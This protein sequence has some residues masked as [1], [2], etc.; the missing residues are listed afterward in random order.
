MVKAKISPKQKKYSKN[1]S[2]Q[3]IKAKAKLI[4]YSPTE[5]IIKGDVI[6]RAIFECLR[7]NDPEGVIEMITIYVNALNKLQA[8]KESDLPRST[9]YHSLKQ[10]NP[11]I[12]TLAKLVSLSA[13]AA[14]PEAR[15]R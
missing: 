2:R 14:Q 1:I 7:D 4:P 11:T 6:A 3:K 10:K 8:A 5:E 9:L 13:G 12:K 15:K